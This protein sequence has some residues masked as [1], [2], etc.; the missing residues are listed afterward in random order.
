MNQDV[1]LNL[2]YYTPRHVQR[3]FD[4]TSRMVEGLNHLSDLQAELARIIGMVESS[5]ET[6]TPYGTINLLNKRECHVKIAGHFAGFKATLDYPIQEAEIIIND[7]LE[8]I[9]SA[10]NGDIS[11]LVQWVHTHSD[12]FARSLTSRYSN[13]KPR[14]RT[15][16]DDRALLIE[17]LHA[18][19]DENPTMTR[20]QAWYRYKEVLKLVPAEEEGARLLKYMNRISKPDTWMAKNL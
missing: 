7:V 10:R 17:H 3:I 4:N 13:L 15:K 8:A 5:I 18:Y 19:I 6:N 1:S 11:L 16:D 9:K 20:N 2:P 14:G 12:T